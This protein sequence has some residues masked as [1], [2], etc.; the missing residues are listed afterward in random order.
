[1]NWLGYHI[2]TPK[3]RLNFVVT[4]ESASAIQFFVSSPIQY[5]KPKWKSTD[6]KFFKYE[7]SL[8]KLSSQ[9]IVVHGGYVVNLPSVREDIRDKSKT[10]FLDELS[11]CEQ[12]GAGNYVFHAG[13]PSTLNRNVG[14]NYVIDAIK[15]AIDTIHDVNIVLEN[16]CESTK[17]C[18][19][20]EEL[21]YIVTHVNSP[22]CGICIDT[23]HYFT[24]TECDKE[25]DP[26]NLFKKLENDGLIDVLKVVHLNDSKTD[27]NSR[28][29]NHENILEGKIPSS[30]WDKFI[31][32]ESLHNIPCIIETP[33]I[34]K[35]F[36]TLIDMI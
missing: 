23:C 11:I 2:P 25:M 21:K 32:N 12:I 29:D 17:L 9:Q 5:L 10:K 36:K 13:S 22:R 4:S 28:K 7:C 1:M 3:G 31:H 33:N 24:S 14:I 35:S 15:L 19:S 27:C 18:N 30:F 6:I 16:A 34:T 8:L 26:I 20:F